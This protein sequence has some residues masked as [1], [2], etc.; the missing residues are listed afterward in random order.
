M[1]MRNPQVV[2]GQQ[3][4]RTLVAAGRNDA[5]VLVRLIRLEQQGADRGI[6]GL[7]GEV[8]RATNRQN[9]IKQAD[10]MA[11]DA[12]QVRIE[13]EF[14][15]RNY[16][17]ERKRQ[18]VKEFAEKA[19]KYRKVKKEDL[20]NALSA[21][22]LGPHTVRRT[23]QWEEK[24]PRL[25][26]GSR[27]ITDYLVRWWASREVASA[28]AVPVEARWVV[29]ASLWNWSDAPVC[30]ALSRDADRQ[31]FL[32]ACQNQDSSILRPLNAAAKQLYVCSKSVYVKE[33]KA[34][35]EDV[36]RSGKP[37]RVLTPDA[38]FRREHV[39]ET[40][41]K[42]ARKDAKRRSRI[43]SLLKKFRSKLG[44]SL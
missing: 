39:S 11:N 4:V 24:Y 3:T 27:P 26:S 18:D 6:V 20:A 44:S 12:E 13:R 2:N 35:S 34:F 40:V 7:V 42:V 8:V 10:L 1:Q 30:D 37:F 21:T 9:A 33:K 29:L 5:K 14:R 16:A 19:F 38:Y 31:A 25:F 15:K 32:R 22:I 17:Y 28:A 23:A 36:R 41:T 43:T